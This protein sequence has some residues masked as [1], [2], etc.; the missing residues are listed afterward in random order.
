MPSSSP[1]C[2]A[3]N[4]VE[5]VWVPDDEREAARDGLRAPEDARDDL[6]RSKQ[7]VE[8]PARHGSVFDF[9]KT[10]PDKERRTDAGRTGL[11]SGRY[12]LRGEGR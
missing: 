12:P 9:E 5:Q 2:S 11:G 3:G 10:L 8:I 4:V 1:A 7:A 6:K